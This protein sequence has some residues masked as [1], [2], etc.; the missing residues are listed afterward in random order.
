MQGHVPRDQPRAAGARAPAQRR[1][2][3][4]LAHAR[5]VG[6]PEAVVRAQ[7]EHRAAVEQHPRPLRAADHAH[8]AV[9][10]EL[11]ELV[12]PVLQ[13]EHRAPSRTEGAASR[14]HRTPSRRTARAPCAGV[15][16]PR[17]D[18]RLPSSDRGPARLPAAPRG[19]RA[20]ADRLR[21]PG[22]LRSTATATATATRP[23]SAL[24]DAF[25][26]STVSVTT[27]GYGDITPVT[28][29]A[30]LVSTLLVTPARVLFLIILVGTT[31]EVLAGRAHAQFR[32]NRWRRTLRGPHDHLRV[33]RQ[34]PRG[35]RDACSRT[36]STPERI[37][38]IDPRA[39]GGRGRAP[40]RLRRAWSATRAARPSLRAAGRRRRRRPSIVAPDRD[41]TAVLITLTARELNRGATIVAAVRDSENAHLLEQGGADSVIV[42]SGAAG[43]AARPGRPQPAHRARAGGP[44]ERGR[45]PR[46]D[47]ARGD[48][49]GGRPARRLPVLGAGDRRR[50]RRRGAALRRPARGASCGRATASS[51]SARTPEPRGSRQPHVQVVV[52]VG[53]LLH[54]P[55][56]PAQAQA[57]GR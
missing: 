17:A 40:A 25:Y 31:L 41:D 2:R 42:S 11:H 52:V 8:A 28:D 49:R 56:R 46:R 35:G 21:G 4:R 30:R 48:R 10:A 55:P 37:V 32:E 22:R 1:L 9:E 50:A 6:Q 23:A 24:L 12:Q 29:R 5:V 51:A 19:G 38:V 34:G 57:A 16:P 27:T 14:R 15:K 44:A 7:Q 45:G 43:P 20:R 26:Y 18:V 36:A 39:G 3:R 54:D 47:R 13:I 33:R 53:E